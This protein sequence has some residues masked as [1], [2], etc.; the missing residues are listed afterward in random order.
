MVAPRKA[1]RRLSAKIC[2]L[3]DANPEPKMSRNSKITTA[4][5]GAHELPSRVHAVGRRTKRWTTTATINAP[6]SISAKNAIAK[7]L[8]IDAARYHGSQPIGND[9]AFEVIGA[10]V[11][12]G[13][14]ELG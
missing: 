10:A 4:V 1:A 9:G 2:M 3:Q 12:H 7:P 8:S 11:L 6:A 5:T 13:K 14:T